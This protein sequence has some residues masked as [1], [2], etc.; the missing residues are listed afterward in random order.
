MGAELDWFVA[1]WWKGAYRLG[2]NQG[3]FTGGISMKFIWFQ[4]DVATWADEIGTKDSPK[5]NRRFMVEM[6][7]DF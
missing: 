2:I 3:Y 4:L 1:N 6:S 5:E 7:L